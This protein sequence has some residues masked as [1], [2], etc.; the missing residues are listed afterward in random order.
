MDTNEYVLNKLYLDPI[1]EAKSNRRSHHQIYMKPVTKTR[2][3][4]TSHSVS[5]I[6]ENLN[7]NIIL[8]SWSTKQEAP[9]EMLNFLNLPIIIDRTKIKRL[10]D[11][12]KK[13]P[14][15]NKLKLKLQKPNEDNSTE[16]K[17]SPG[18]IDKNIIAEPEKEFEFKGYNDNLVNT[19]LDT[20]KLTQQIKICKKSEKSC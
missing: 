1:S 16:T 14:S 19:D 2:S 7:G 11:Q 10:I 5:D 17:L 12:S 4:S 13:L 20:K 18:E 3:L 6:M 8:Q 9:K 15:L